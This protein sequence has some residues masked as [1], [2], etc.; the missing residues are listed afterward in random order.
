MWNSVVKQ[1]VGVRFCAQVEPKAVETKRDAQKK[2]RRRIPVCIVRD[3]M[4]RNCGE[5]VQTEKSMRVPRRSYFYFFVFR[6]V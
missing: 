5:V 4:P 3:G 2:R 1:N 6:L